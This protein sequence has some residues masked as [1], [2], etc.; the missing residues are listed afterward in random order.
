[1]RVELLFVLMITNVCA[2]AYLRWLVKAHTY[3]TQTTLFAC[4]FA[5][6]CVSCIVE[7]VSLKLSIRETMRN[8]RLYVA[9]KNK[10]TAIKKR[11]EWP[12]AKMCR[13]CQCQLVPFYVMNA[14]FFFFWFVVFFFFCMI[15]FCHYQRDPVLC[16]ATWT[17]AFQVWHNF[18]EDSPD[19]VLG[20][21]IK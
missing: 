11:N 5:V 3:S 18:C 7:V 20:S 6:V 9:I 8:G 4:M 12:E 15:F 14:F 17:N 21:L 19:I 2:C 10:I 16:V 1:M 13:K